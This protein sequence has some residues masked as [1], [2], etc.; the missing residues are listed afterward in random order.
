MIDC[1]NPDPVKIEMRN[2]KISIYEV[3]STKF[4]DVLAMEKEGESQ[5]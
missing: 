1:S 3:K 2:G 5:G 4:S